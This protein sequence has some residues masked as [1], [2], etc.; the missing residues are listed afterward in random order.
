M[1]ILLPRISL[2][3]AFLCLLFTTRAQNPKIKCYFNHP[4][5][6]NLATGT[7]AIYLNGTFPDTI[8]AYINNAKYSLDIA[9]YNFTSRGNDSVA[10]IATAVNDAFA[11]G[12]T[13]RWVYNGTSATANSGM[14]LL[15]AAIPRIGSPSGNGYNIM[16]NKFVVVDANS[17]DTNDAIVITGSYNFSQQQTFGDYNN[18]LIVQDQNVALAYQ[19]QFNKMWGGAGAAPDSSKSTFGTFKTPSS[20]NYFNV[21]GTQVQVRFSPSDT[22]G[23]YLRTMAYTANNDL[24]FGIYTF[25]DN[26]LANAILSKFNS[27]ISVRGIMDGSSKSYNPYTTLSTPLGANMAVFNN[28]NLLYHNKI[29]VVD[30][31]LP[32]SDPQVATGSFNWTS[33]AQYTNDENLLIIHDAA[34][35][36]QYYQ[37]ICDNITVNGGN[38]C[39]APL[40][41]EW[42]SFDASLNSNGTA[43]LQWVTA[44]EVN[45]DHFEIERSTDGIV[46]ENDGNVANGK[47]GDY[48]FIDKKVEAGANY[49]R[50]KQVDDDGYFTY[51]KVL[52][53]YNRTGAT[54][55]LYPNPALDKLNILL[56]LGA[57]SVSVYDAYGTKVIQQPV[58]GK[59]ATQINVNALS[60]GSYYIE[61]LGK[62][63]KF[64]KPFIKQ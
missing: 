8:V 38:A 33:S 24:T 15:N 56:P 49:F 57:V 11:R 46:F 39:I 14:K 27:G 48:Q 40:P 54:I 36:N 22:A 20:K 3:A 58:K 60:K 51:S 44:N 55:S 16:H 6:N 9:V 1:K 19:N 62:G 53:V 26:S 21:G 64:I 41:V 34:I 23:Y 47:T 31:L 63:S 45:N 2:V 42:V 12:V 43:T 59:P 52:S 61:I 18:L 7:N 37:S 4:V 10:K 5:N 17:P 25:T 28:N 35:A 13:V 29:L 30:A 50:I 32:S